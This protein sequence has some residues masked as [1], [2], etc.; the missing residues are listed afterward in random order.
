M[1][2]LAAITS[3]LSA[4]IAR[5]TLVVF[6]LHVALA[7]AAYWALSRPTPAAEDA[8]KRKLFRSIVFSRVAGLVNVTLDAGLFLAALVGTLSGPAPGD[9]LAF[10]ALVIGL[11]LAGSIAVP[12]SYVRLTPAPQPLTFLWRFTLPLL[13]LDVG[14]TWLAPSWFA[15]PLA[16]PPLLVLLTHETVRLTYFLAKKRPRF[17]PFEVADL[18]RQD[19]E[20]FDGRDVL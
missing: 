2:D 16:I 13:G 15:I 20:Q 14:L 19:R 5:F 6:V 11:V 1:N 10:N 12:L 18:D 4:P 7:F 9:D 17:L 8:A 3:H